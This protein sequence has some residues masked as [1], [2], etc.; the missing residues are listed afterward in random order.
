PPPVTTALGALLSHVTGGGDAKT[1][2]PMNVNF[3]LF[4]PPPAMPNKAGKLRPPKGRDRR[5]A[6][7]AR[8]A[9]D[10]DAGLSAPATRAS[11]GPKWPTGR[12]RA[13]AGPKD[14]QRPRAGA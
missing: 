3:G 8:A 10:F 11:S 13:V 7:T 6:M 2:Q 9:V 12:A 1:F 14:L 4:P 5:Q